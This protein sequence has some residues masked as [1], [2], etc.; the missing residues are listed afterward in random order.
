VT[1]PNPRPASRVKS[2]RR[3]PV[4]FGAEVLTAKAPQSAKDQNQLIS[5][6][7]ALFGALAVSTSGLEL[8]SPQGGP[9]N[10]VA[11]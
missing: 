8:S 11:A 2:V 9:K 4:L 1:A 10:A 7:L 6:S 3:G 5:G